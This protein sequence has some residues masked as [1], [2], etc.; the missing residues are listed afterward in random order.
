MKAGRKE[1]ARALLRDLK[2]IVDDSRNQVDPE[3]R[4]RFDGV[5]ALAEGPG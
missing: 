1:Q 5:A 2:T 4:T 3:L